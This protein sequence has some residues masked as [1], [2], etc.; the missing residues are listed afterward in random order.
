[1]NELDILC[2]EIRDC[3]I[4]DAHLPLG[5]KPVFTAAVDSKI[6]LVGQAPGLRVHNTGIPWNDKSGQE[7]RRWLGVTEQEFYNPKL[8][9]I[10][11][12]GFCYPG[13]S[14]T[15]DLPPRKECASLW[16]GPLL[17]HLPNI[18]LI[19][20][21]GQYAQKYYLKDRGYKNL[22]ESVKNHLNFL[23]TYFPLPHP[24][25]RNFVWR[26]KNRWFESEVLPELKR[27][28]HNII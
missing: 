27:R 4:C 3:K 19:L 2:K 24:S 17:E 1:M 23:P 25:P 20:L 9:S 12:M 21:V 5:A 11:P 8:F 6:L 7:L 10:V 14:K 13:K 15:G 26:N 22:T 28:V 18:E 16:H